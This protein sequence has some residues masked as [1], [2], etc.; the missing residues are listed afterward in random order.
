M[1][2]SNQHKHSACPC[3]LSAFVTTTL[4]L[5]ALAIGQAGSAMAEGMRVRVMTQNMYVGSAF[6][7]LLAS[8]ST[9]EDLKAAVTKIYNNILASK[10]NERAIAVAK[11][12][13][14]EHPDII[15]LQEA[16]IL[17]TGAAGA[18]ATK[19]ETDQLEDLL[20]ELHQQGLP[21]EVIAIVPNLDAQAPTQL[22]FDVRLTDRTVIIAEQPDLKLTNMR[23]QDY[24]VNS[25]VIPPADAGIPI[26]INT[27]GWASV[28]LTLSGHGLQ[29]ATTHFDNFPQFQ[30]A[31]QRAQA[32]EAI[33]SLTNP[34]LPI[35]FMGDFNLDPASLKLPST[36][37]LLINA[38]FSDA[39]KQ[40]H[41][42]DPGFTCCQ[43][44]NL[45]NPNS[46]LSTRMDLVL[47]RGAVS[48]EDIKLVG[49]QPSDRTPSDPPLWPSD[50]AGLLATLRI[51]TPSVFVN[52]GNDSPRPVKSTGIVVG[53]ADFPPGT[54]VNINLDA[55]SSRGTAT[56]GPDGSF[57]WDV[58]IQP[59]LKCAVGV[60]AT[61]HGADGI[62]VTAEG[63]VFCPPARDQLR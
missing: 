63:E 45:Q 12:I 22:S 21:Y 30:F 14:T 37:Q 31:I 17:R 25:K 44:A 6:S 53:G 26:I 40:R 48:V 18:P 49:D 36:Y 27:R 62:V 29:I 16:W 57:E 15:A 11:E 59:P 51:L 54:A 28:E 23:V 34:A 55:R 20:N 2:N 38:G 39:W 50:H 61:V 32:G 56:V 13:K 10:P 35:V 33:R 42:S 7:A 3:G 52:A 47:T 60:G 19:V 46:E 5:L 1:H 24:L 58:S 4:T 41:P 8:V 9:V 43:D